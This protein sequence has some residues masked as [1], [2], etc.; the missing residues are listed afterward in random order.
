WLTM[1]AGDMDGDG[2]TDLVL[3]SFL[4][5]PATIPIPD[6]LQKRWATNKTALLV[7]EN[8]KSAKRT[9]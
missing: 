8:L 4:P 3:G 9:P 7:L 1:A 2:D 6:S 5:G